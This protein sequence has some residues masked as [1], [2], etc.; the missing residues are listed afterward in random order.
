MTLTQKQRRLRREIEKIASMITMDHWNIEC[1]APAQRT[2][3]LEI[4][5]DKLIRGEVVLKYTL[6][7]EFLTN[8]ICD[9]YFRRPAKGKTYRDLWKTKRFRI[10]VHYIMDE[11]FLMKKLAAVDAIKRVPKDVSSALARIN[12]TRNALAH[13]F[14]PQNRRRYVATK[15]VVHDGVPLFTSEGVEKFHHDVE[16]AEAYL[17]RRAFGVILEA[18]PGADAAANK[19][20]AKAFPTA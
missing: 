2:T 19:S 9:F 14:F 18:D 7:E 8:I 6:L 20:M 3:Y 10:F 16:V 1:Y 12:D 17:M 13:T 15:T 5:R 11:T 4:M